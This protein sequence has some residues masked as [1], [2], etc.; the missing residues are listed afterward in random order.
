MGNQWNEKAK[1][2]ESITKNEEQER[3]KSIKIKLDIQKFERKPFRLKR[4]LG[5]EKARENSVFLRQGQL[6]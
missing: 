5:G 3:E 4:R 2:G 1:S 6:P